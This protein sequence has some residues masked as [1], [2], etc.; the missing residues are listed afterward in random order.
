MRLFIHTHPHTHSNIHTHTHTHTHTH[1][2]SV[3]SDERTTG[4]R[5]TAGV[6]TRTNARIRY[7]QH[8]KYT[9]GFLSVVRVCHLCFT[10]ARMCAR[11]HDCDSNKLQVCDQ[12]TPSPPPPPTHTRTHIHTSHHFRCTSF[13]SVKHAEKSKHAYQQSVHGVPSTCAAGRVS[14]ARGAA[15]DHDRYTH[16]RQCNV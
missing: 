2:C 10:L 15:L 4:V 14:V 3:H 12:Y 6:H 8:Y 1:A 9:L 16:T 13:T 7:S 5:Q 11:M